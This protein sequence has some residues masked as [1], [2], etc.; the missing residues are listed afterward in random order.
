LVEAAE[1]LAAVVGRA[2]AA[3]VGHR[4]GGEPTP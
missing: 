3:V 4:A 2:P 1:A